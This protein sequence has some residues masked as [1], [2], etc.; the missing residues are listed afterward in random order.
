[1]ACPLILHR[2]CRSLLK[3]QVDPLDKLRA[4]PSAKPDQASGKPALR[5]GDKTDKLQKFAN[6]LE[7]QNEQQMSTARLKMLRAGYR[8]KN[9]VRIFHAAQFALGIGLLLIGVIFAMVKSATAEVST[10]MLV[11][12]T[13]GPGAA[14]YYL[15]QYWVQRRL[16][17]RQGE[18]H[19]RLPRRAR[20]DARLRRS[21]PVARPVDPPRRQGNPRRLS[22]PRRRIRDRGAGGARPARNASSVLKDMAERV[23]LPDV[24]SFVT[25]LIQSATFGTS[26][27]D[28]LRVYAAKCATSA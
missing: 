27:A 21:G 14:G 25:V 19:R 7:P 8:S 2:R 15:P 10:Q 22:R 12:M 24:S 16:Q 11:M 6:F 20:H 3:K 9:A 18:H 1:M 28:A 17:T 5:R 23:G 13:I 26:I 4:R